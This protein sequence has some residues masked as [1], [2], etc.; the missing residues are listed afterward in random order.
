MTTCELA[1]CG[2]GLV[3][4][5]VEACDDGND[6]GD[7]CTTACA[8][9]RCGDGFVQRGVEECDDG[10]DDETDNCNVPVNLLSAVTATFGP[11]RGLRRWECD[12]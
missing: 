12:R 4:L 9:P 11:G 7:E 5:G 10:N 3:Q 8:L 6:D 2:D 1:R